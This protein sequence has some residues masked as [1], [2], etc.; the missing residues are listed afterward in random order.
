VLASGA[1]LEAHVDVA[2]LEVEQ[3]EGFNR[4][5]MD[6]MIQRLREKAAELG[7]D[8][9]YV[10]NTSAHEGDHS[11]MDPDSSLLL[12]S[13]VVFTPLGAAPSTPIET[14]GTPRIQLTPAPR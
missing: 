7:C 1:P 4:R 5:G 9:V 10:K 12:A 6:Y 14:A 11:W 3:S 8:A 2:L 13:C